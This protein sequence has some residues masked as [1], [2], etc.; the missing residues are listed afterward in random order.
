MEVLELKG[1]LAEE[2]MK[3][4]IEKLYEERQRAREGDKEHPRKSQ[5]TEVTT[6]SVVNTGP[7]SHRAR[8]VDSTT[9]GKLPR[10]HGGANQLSTCVYNWS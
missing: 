9:P 3:Q 1:Q 6:S 10:S 8:V 5:E 7:L 4:W 2:P